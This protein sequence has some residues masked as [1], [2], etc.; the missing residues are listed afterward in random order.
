[1]PLTLQPRRGGFAALLILLLLAAPVWAAKKPQPA[2]EFPAGLPW[3]NVER[4]LTM[5]DLRG[6]VVILDFWTYGCIN[7]LH[8]AAELQDLER[9][10]GDDLA[11]IGVHS[12]K[13]DNEENIETL[14][15]MLVRLDRRHPVVSDTGHRMMRMYGARAWP[16]LVVIDTAGG[17]VGYVSGEGNVELFG[18]LIEKLLKERKLDA[19]A[20][21]LPLAPE[22]NRF[23]GALLAAPA[24]LSIDGGRIAISDSLKHR[25]LVT[26][27]TGNVLEIIGSGEPGLRD[28][29]SKQAQFKAPQGVLL[30]GDRLYV[31]DAGNH[32]VR[33][34]DLDTRRVKTIAGTGDI[35]LRI[36]GKQDALKADLRSP[37]DLALDGNQL[38]IA[39]AGSHQI[40]KL[41]L[42]RGGI[43]PWAGYGGEGIADGPLKSAT[44]SQPSGLSLAGNKLY[45]ADAEASAVREIDLESKQVTTLVGKGLF[46]FGDRD[47]P[48]R[49]VLLQHVSGVAADEDGK[50]FLADSYNHKLKR[51]DLDPVSVTTLAG[52]GKPGNKKRAKGGVELNEPG[53][54]EIDGNHLLAAD[55]NNGRILRYDLETGKIAEWALRRPAKVAGYEGEKNR[56]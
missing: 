32:V 10:F 7:C 19:V 5:K 4:P 31:A 23:A 52:T 42:A 27:K 51:L 38:Y 26:D 12:P 1:M 14:R 35:G 48:A 13:F 30:R 36:R 45:V 6:R 54:V 18:S 34:I 16:T 37:W 53:D 25:V 9:R 43:K 46:D 3:L 17:V 39:M 50:L 8:V 55:T 56:K 47:G 22:N 41:D 40:W 20:G 49:K 44:F 2:P 15:R 11:V 24:K 33:E 29:A 21:A 28:G